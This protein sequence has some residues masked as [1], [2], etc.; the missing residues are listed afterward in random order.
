MSLDPGEVTAQGISYGRRMVKTFY[1]AEVTVGDL[2]AEKR[3]RDWLGDLGW[4]MLNITDGG[5]G[6][7]VLNFTYTEL[8]A[9]TD[10][11]DSVAMDRRWKVR[12]G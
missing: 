3:V 1:T 8:V 5:D 10:R 11:G 9:D 6:R 12:G 7:W 4:K 2:V